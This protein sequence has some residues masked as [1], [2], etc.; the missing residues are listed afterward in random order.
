MALPLVLLLF[1]QLASMAV[2]RT[3]PSPSPSPAPASHHPLLKQLDRD[4][5]GVPRQPPGIPSLRAPPDLMK[6]KRHQGRI[7]VPASAG[8]PKLNYG[9]KIGLAFA[10]VAAGLQVALGGVL[11]LKR[12]QLKKVERDD[13]GTAVSSSNP[14]P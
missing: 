6:H 1:S 3:S 8:K 14:P 11:V 10:G 12:R 2:S 5:D 13:R 4:L 7:P 9:E